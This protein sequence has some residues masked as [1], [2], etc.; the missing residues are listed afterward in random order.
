VKEGT[1]EAAAAASPL[2]RIGNEEFEVTR[3]VVDEIGN[4]V[5]ES[6]RNS[7]REPCGLTSSRGPG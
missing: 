3:G 6:T 5:E 1:A 2:N 7:T 4:R